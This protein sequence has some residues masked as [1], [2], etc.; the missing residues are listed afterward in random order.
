MQ[1]IPTIRKITKYVLSTPSGTAPVLLAIRLIV[2]ATYSCQPSL[3]SFKV[4]VY[5]KF[6]GSHDD[7]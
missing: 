6:Q 5:M 3:P 2:A 7:N 4:I 1:F